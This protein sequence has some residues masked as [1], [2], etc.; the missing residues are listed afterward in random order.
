MFAF[1]NI[2]NTI[3]KRILLCVSAA[4]LL[5]TACDK[6][7]DEPANVTPTTTNVAGSYK[8]TAASV[9]GA[10]VFG[11]YEACE[12]DDIHTF[13]A[14]SSPATS[15]TYT[16]TD[17]GTVCSP[18]TADSGT[19]T[20]VNSTSIDINGLVYNIVSFNNSTMVV[21]FSFGGATYQETYTRQ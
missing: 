18:T 15:G 16:L 7:E 9:N 3:M 6:D 17:A 14:Y 13:A 20:L 5:L 12:K 4:V 8:I 19:W 21:S 1:Q 10:D 11:Q 2:Q